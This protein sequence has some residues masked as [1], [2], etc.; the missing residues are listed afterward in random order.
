M[1]IVLATCVG[2]ALTSTAMAQTAPGHLH[3]P[4]CGHQLVSQEGQLVWTASNATSAIKA[5]PSSLRTGP[6]FVLNDIGG[7]GPGT[8]ARA[9]FE[10][11]AARWSNVFTDPITIRLDVGFSALGTGILGSTG[12]TANQI[13]Y[14]GLQGLLA[15]DRSST[16]DNSAVRNLPGAP[17]AYVSN[18][19]GTC[20][21]NGPDCGPIDSRVRV[22]DADNTTDNNF[23]RI[24]TANVKALGIAPVYNATTNPLGRDGTVRFSTLFNFDYD[25][26]DGIGAGLIDFVGVA[27][28]EIGHALGF[29]SGVDTA[30]INGLPGV[31]LPGRAGLDNIA[32]GST[33]DLYRY[34]AFP[35]STSE[36][37]LS[38][39]AG[40]SPCLSLDSGR[41]CIAPLS[42]GSLNGDRRQASHWKDDILL[43]ITPPLGIMDPTATGPLG[44]RPFQRITR[45]DLIA[46]DVIGYNLFAAVPSPASLALFGFGLAGLAVARRRRG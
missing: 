19:P 7:V 41:T 45:N 15:L 13:N 43:G 25:P 39:A 14:T 3:G 24:N 29:V 44:D 28:H 20:P 16:R 46:F 4:A 1:K 9:A 6:T 36:R 32:Y 2:V 23:I 42:T 40:G 10:A 35:F 26:T 12:S 17:L 8:Q 31:A 21:P 38:W 37:V 18:E 11:A 5:G 30:D 27:T 33:L 22:I 34:D